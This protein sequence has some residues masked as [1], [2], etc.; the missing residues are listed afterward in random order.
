MAA[1]TTPIF[2]NSPVA[3]IATFTSATAVT[4]R[5]NRTGTSGLIQLTPTSTNG[6]RVDRISVHSK[7]TSAA[8]I[9]FIWLYDGTTAFLIDEIPIAVVTASNTVPAFDVY[10]TYNNLILPSTY[11]LYVSQTVQTDCNVVAWGGDY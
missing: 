8:S 6:K 4:T 10:N 3:G 11:Q 7:A 1:N 9:V 2:P 5:T